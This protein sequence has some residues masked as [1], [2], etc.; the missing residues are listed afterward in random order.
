M[1]LAIVPLNDNNDTEAGA[2]MLGDVG[3]IDGPVVDLHK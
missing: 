1:V 2:A 3:S